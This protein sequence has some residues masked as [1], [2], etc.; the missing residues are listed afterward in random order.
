MALF[1]L[2]HSKSGDGIE[3]EGLSLKYI[4]NVN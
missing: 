4:R 2:A 3:P 1:D